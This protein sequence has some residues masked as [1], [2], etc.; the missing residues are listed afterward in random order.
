[1]DRVIMPGS[2]GAVV[3]HVPCLSIEASQDRSH[4]RVD[5]GALLVARTVRL[6]SHW[7]QLA[8]QLAVFGRLLLH[9]E[10]I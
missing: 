5:Q 4:G 7:Q 9:W 8:I 10:A 6:M 1:M 3:S 2:Q